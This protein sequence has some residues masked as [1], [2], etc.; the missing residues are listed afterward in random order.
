MRFHLIP[1]LLLATHSIGW[2]AIGWAGETTFRILGVKGKTLYEA[3][4]A[5]STKT[6]G[7]SALSPY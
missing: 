7:K 6:V 2:A 5:Q 1:F 3:Q 4:V